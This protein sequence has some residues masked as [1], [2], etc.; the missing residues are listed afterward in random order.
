MIKFRCIV[1][2]GSAI[3]SPSQSIGITAN[4]P[5]ALLLVV[6]LYLEPPFAEH[7]FL[8]IFA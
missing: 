6:A 1:L 4:E 7:V 8:H 2:R 5:L 3:T